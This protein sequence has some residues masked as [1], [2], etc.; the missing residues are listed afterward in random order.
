[1]Q[2]AE[3]AV[4]PAVLE[5]VTPVIAPDL[6]L[7]VALADALKQYLPVAHAADAPHLHA[8]GPFTCAAVPSVVAQFTTAPLTPT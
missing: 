5:Q 3:T 4:V 8:L 1:M 7:V 6:H 2:S